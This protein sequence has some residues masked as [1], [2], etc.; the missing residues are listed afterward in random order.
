[1]K[2]RHLMMAALAA[3]LAAPALLTGQ[4]RA[5]TQ[6]WPSQPVKLVVPAPPGSNADSVGRVVADQ[7][8]NV[9]PQ[10]VLVD[11]KPGAGGVIGIEQVMRAPPDGQTFVLVASTSLNILPHLRPV[12]YDPF[13]SLTPVAQVGTYLSIVACTLSLNVSTLPE[14]MAL[15]RTMPGKLNYGTNGAGSFGHLAAERLKHDFKVDIVHVPYKGTAEL[16]AALLAGE[17]QMVIDPIVLP[18]IKAGKVRGLATFA[19]FRHPELPDVPSLNEAGVDA[20]VYPATAGIM[21]PN[22]TPETIVKRVSGIMRDFLD[23]AQAKETMLRFGVAPTYLDGPVFLADLRAA[24][25]ANRKII[26]EA[27]ITAA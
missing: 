27:K 25:E 18:Q 26:V 6:D 11:N 19:G 9:L 4:A 24:S 5:Q 2:R 8:G 20:V 15:A 21:A 17:I 23:T 16:A 7:L 13:T 22:G 12:P 10:R 3:P 1:M 14:L